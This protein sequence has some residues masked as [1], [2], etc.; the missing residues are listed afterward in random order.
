MACDGNG[1][2][3]WNGCGMWLEGMEIIWASS[4]DGILCLV[5][6]SSASL[7]RMHRSISF[8]IWIGLGNWC[9]WLGIHSFACRCSIIL[10]RAW[11]HGDP[12]VVYPSGRVRPV[13]TF[14][15]SMRISVQKG[16]RESQRQATLGWCRW[17]IPSRTSGSYRFWSCRYRPQ[18]W[19]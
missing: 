1:G 3:D 11:Q 9:C 17:L 15:C 13:A 16:W 18:C 7:R 6:L 10:R 2:N 5:G 12:L 4:R 14:P 8:R 19:Y